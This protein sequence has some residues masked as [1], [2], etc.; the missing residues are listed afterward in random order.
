[1][2]YISESKYQENPE[3]CKIYMFGNKT[4]NHEITNTSTEYVKTIRHYFSFG[5]FFWSTFWLTH[6]SRNI[7]NLINVTK[8][9]KNT[10]N[11]VY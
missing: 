11:A 7:L 5:L 1:M 9:D 10:M 4:M 6:K 3:W 2:G 8:M